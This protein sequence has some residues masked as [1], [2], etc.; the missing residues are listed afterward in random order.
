MWFL[1]SVVYFVGMAF[2]LSPSEGVSEICCLWAWVGSVYFASSH[3]TY[4][5]LC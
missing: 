3:P 5:D 4:V 2:I 1:C